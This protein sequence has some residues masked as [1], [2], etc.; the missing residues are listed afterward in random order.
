MH[1]AGTI[2]PDEQTFIPA[3]S[4]RAVIVKARVY[5]AIYF[6]VVALSLWHHS[7]L[8]LM[9]VG[10]P[11]LYG[12]WLMPIYG[13][14]QHAGLAEDVLD[15]RL[16]CRTVTMNRVNRYLY[17]N[18]NYHVEHHMYPLVPYHHLPRLHEL[19]KADMPPAYDG[20]LAAWREII[21]AVLRQVKEPSYYVQ[22]E[23][24]AAATRR[25]ASHDVRTLVSDGVTTDDG[26]LDVAA[27]DT[28]A[29]EDVLRFDV[30]EQT[31]AIYRAGDGQYYAS[32]GVCTHG[33]A[34]LAGGVVR[35]YEIE[36][37]KHNGRFDVRDGSP[38]RLPVCLAV[39]AYPVRVVEG[40]LKVDIS[41]P[42]ASPDP[43]V[44]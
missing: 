44:Q 31:L 32:D 34:H 33:R 8:P 17:W 40:R 26:W 18:M 39:R 29:I 22:R 3:T 41:P 15:H 28:L 6:A 43:A 16:N 20:L 38:R 4:W 2:D 36:C 25:P 21:P 24:P 7:L 27:A 42:A 12:H 14:T 30:G 13:Y 5:L 37:P 11:N 1:S 35:G 10:L 23:L 9:Y 19:L